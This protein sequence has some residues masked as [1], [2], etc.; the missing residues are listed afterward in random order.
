M[1]I[2]AKYAKYWTDVDFIFLGW[3]EQNAPWSLGLPK[4]SGILMEFSTVLGIWKNIL[5]SFRPFQGGDGD[6]E[7]RTAVLRGGNAGGGLS[8][9]YA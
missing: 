4:H 5:Q 1:T 8:S 3:L 6:P 2:Q 7:L 9:V